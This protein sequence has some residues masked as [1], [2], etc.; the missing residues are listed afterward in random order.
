MSVISTPFH[1]TT[2][3]SNEGKMAREGKRRRGI[4]DEPAFG[5]QRVR[6]RE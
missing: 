4:V 1:R 3:W 5:E 2:T 6:N